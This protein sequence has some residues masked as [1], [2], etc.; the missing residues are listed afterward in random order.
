MSAPQSEAFKTAVED[1]K[2]LTSKPG[3]T[4]LL[5]LYSLY[6]GKAKYNA[7]KKVAED[8]KLTPEAAQ[9]KYVEHVEKLK[10]SCGYDANKVPETVGA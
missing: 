3:P 4:E 1:S 8:D 10:K 6:K 9:A 5:E 7:W 2:K